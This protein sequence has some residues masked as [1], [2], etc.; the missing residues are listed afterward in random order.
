MID[1]IQQFIFD[2]LREMDVDTEGID[3]DS[4]LGPRGADL[5]SLA[6]AE[7]AL[8]VEDKYGLRFGEEETERL[9]GLTVAEFCAVVAE[10]A[11]MTPA[12]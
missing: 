1:S 4:Q 2:S 8:R 6:L 12:E 10:R 7:L 5:S 11:T 9:A 3:A